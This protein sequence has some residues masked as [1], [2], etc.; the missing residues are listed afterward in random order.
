MLSESLSNPEVR[1]FM[2]V[3]K[4]NLFLLGKIVLILMV[5]ILINKVVFEP[6]YNELQFML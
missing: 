1:N 4:T 5:P 2:L 3:E 6:S